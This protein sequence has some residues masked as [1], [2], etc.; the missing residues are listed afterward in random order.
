MNKGGKKPPLTHKEIARLI[1]EIADHIEGGDWSIDVQMSI[2][3]VQEALVELGLMNGAK[4]LNRIALLLVS[5][6]GERKSP[7]KYVQQAVDALLPLDPVKDS[8]AL[9]SL[10]DEISRNSAAN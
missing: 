1:T 7:Y 6:N 3:T 5:R 10:A 9:R 8:N 4:L 2:L